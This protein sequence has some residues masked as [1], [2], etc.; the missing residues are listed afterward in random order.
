[1]KKPKRSNARH[2][3]EFFT[4]AFVFL[5]TAVFNYE[6]IEPKLLE[7]LANP[8]EVDKAFFYT[9]IFTAT[10]GFGLSLYHPFSKRKKSS[11]E[12]GCMAMFMNLFQFLVG[13][14]SLGLLLIERGNTP[15]IE[16]SRLEI[17]PIA[18]GTII[19]VLNMS[20]GGIRILMPFK[21]IKMK[22]FDIKISNKNTKP[23]AL[24]IS[25]A[26]STSF[27]LFSHYILKQTMLETM[28]MALVL[29]FFSFSVLASLPK[30]L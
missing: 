2:E 26:L 25:M 6:I 4:V 20:I 23:K 28:N 12:I 9:I 5:I 16:I 19:S 22:E 14:Y 13:L 24:I 18:L 29:S 8:P 17:I 30:K 10:L 21:R 11:L 7:A 27:V 1:M 3:M 15:L